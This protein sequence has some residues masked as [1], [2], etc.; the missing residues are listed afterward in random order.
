M[1]TL[2]LSLTQLTAENY[3]T[4]YSFENWMPGEAH[5]SAPNHEHQHP[6]D[7]SQT[8]SG[9][10]GG[11][12]MSD[13]GTPNPIPSSVMSSA[14]GT[15]AITPEL[16]TS[17]SSGMTRPVTSTG[18]LGDHGEEKFPFVCGLCHDCY[19]RRYTVKRHFPECVKKHGNDGNLAWDSH[20]S[21]KQGRAYKPRG[22]NRWNRRGESGQS[23][24]GV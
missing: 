7:N 19:T 20:P 17:V 3:I 1:K 16:S 6:L 22:S 13:L 12:G 10:V 9:G 8:T 15:N 4:A 2:R 18:T 11:T 21:C 24:H 23:V 5:A 14:I